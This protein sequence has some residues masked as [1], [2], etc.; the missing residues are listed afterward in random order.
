MV[1]EWDKCGDLLVIRAEEQ[2]ISEK[3]AP[4]ESVGHG[5]AEQKIHLLP[6][7]T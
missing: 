2:K 1:A 3:H 7:S 6:A 4:E 5:T